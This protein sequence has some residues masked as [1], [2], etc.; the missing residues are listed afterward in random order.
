MHLLG[1]AHNMLFVRVFFGG[2]GGG[3]GGEIILLTVSRTVHMSDPP[4]ANRPFAMTRQ[5]A[6]ACHIIWIIDR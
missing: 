4:N 3:G 5:A 2:H 1:S 6:A